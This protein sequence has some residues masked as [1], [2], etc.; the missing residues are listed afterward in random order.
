MVFNAS[1]GTNM[2]HGDNFS[3]SYT[4]QSQPLLDTLLQ[5]IKI[6][7]IRKGFKNLKFSNWGGLVGPPR[8]HF[9]I[10]KQK[11]KTKNCFKMIYML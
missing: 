10:K 11:N 9:P 8:D 2:Y 6:W 3:D 4:Y 1:S 5:T 7:S